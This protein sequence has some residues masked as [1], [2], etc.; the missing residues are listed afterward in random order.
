MIEPTPFWVPE[1]RDAVEVRGEDALRYLQGQVSQD[2][3]PLTVGD[4]CW[5]FVLQPTGKIDV[6]AR[7]WRRAGDAFVL[8]T[9]AGHGDVL[10][11]RLARFK[12]RVQADI[13]PLPWRAVAVRGTAD[14]ERPAGSVVGWWGRDYDVLA[15]APT[16]PAGID[17]ADRDTLQRT[18][19]EAGWPAMG[20]EI[21][22]GETIP[23]ETGIAAVAV[24]YTKG[25]YPGQELV[26]R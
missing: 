10:V 12:I 9:D 21:T 11:A 5:T 26:E 25:C 1:Q 20:A 22:T 19:V 4:S 16:A 2:L 15:E 14:G 8:D 13:E 18:R 23:A 3:A 6:L 24:S 17:E 7:V